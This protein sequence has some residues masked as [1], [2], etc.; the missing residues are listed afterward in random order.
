MTNSECTITWYCLQDTLWLMLISNRQQELPGDND[1]LNHPCATI[2]EI[3][4]VIQDLYVP[5]QIITAPCIQIN[6]AY[7]ESSNLNA[8]FTSSVFEVYSWGLEGIN[9]DPEKSPI[10]CLLHRYWMG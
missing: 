10:V 7:T 6:R 8:L 2:I 4:V 3:A 1:A 9:W 5:W